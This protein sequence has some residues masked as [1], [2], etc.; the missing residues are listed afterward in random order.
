MHT[1]YP[2]IT[3]STQLSRTTQLSHLT[4]NKKDQKPTVSIL[5]SITAITV[6][7]MKKIQLLLFAICI[8]LAI[9]TLTPHVSPILVILHIHKPPKY[10]QLLV[11]SPSIIALPTMIEI[12]VLIQFSVK[13]NPMLLYLKIK[14]S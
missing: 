6:G 1:P 2:S 14:K 8:S 11:H 10:E 3:N 5:I 13:A 9:L 7:K 4:L 12:T